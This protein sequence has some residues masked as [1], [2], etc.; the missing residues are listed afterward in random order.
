MR[1]MR[2]R[3][4]GGVTSAARRRAEQYFASALKGGKL[5]KLVKVIQTLSLSLP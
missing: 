5:A 4:E 3:R 1:W 2:H